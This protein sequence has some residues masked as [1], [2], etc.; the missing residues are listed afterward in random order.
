MEKDNTN[1]IET[2]NKSKVTLKSKKSPSPILVSS[3]ILANLANK[4]QI[5]ASTKTKGEVSGGG[6]KPWRQK[7][8]GRARAGSNRSPIWVGGGI[9]FGPRLERNFSKR[10]NKKQKSIVLNHLLEE[11]NKEG[12]LKI[13]EKV[14]LKSAK[15]KE[16]LN[17]LASLGIDNSTILILDDDF[18]SSENSEKIYFAGRNISFLKIISASKLNAYMILKYKWAVITKK[19]LEDLNKRTEPKK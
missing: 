7:G 16:L 2:V 9:T 10:I 18:S 13:I 8:T 15:T 11:K 12:N 19:A 3:V 17:Y 5:S 6:K 14:D 4:R 1:T